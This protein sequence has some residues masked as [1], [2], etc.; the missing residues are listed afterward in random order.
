MIKQ[1]IISLFTVLICLFNYGQV[2]V[3]QYDDDGKRHGEWRKNFEGTNQLRYEGQFEHGKE[4]GVFKFYQKVGKVSKLAATKEFNAVNNLANTI[5]YTLAGKVMSEGQMDGKNY[6]GKWV[7]YHKN[8]EQP[9]TIEHYNNQGQLH[10][11]KSVYY[12][13]GQ[14]SEEVNYENGKREGV[15]KHYAL[16][17]TMIQ[18]YNYVND[19]LHGETKHYDDQNNLTIEGQYKNDK[20][21]GVWNYYSNGKFVREKNWSYK[22]K[23]TKN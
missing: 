15:E 3:N 13:T 14:L 1:N 9:M 5:F 22:P 16:N 10:G 21:V 20:K 12:I 8:S 6:V 17:G 4:V 11:M 7:Y 18:L 23:R 2:K 19:E